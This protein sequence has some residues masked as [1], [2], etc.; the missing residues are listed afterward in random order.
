MAEG[1]VSPVPSGGRT[2][3]QAVR[4]NAF[5]S[6]VRNGSPTR[7]VLAASPSPARRR[8]N[9]GRY[10]AERQLLEG[11][12]QLLGGVSREQKH[13]GLP[14]LVLRAFF[15]MPLYPVKYVQ[16]LIQ[17][18]YEVSPPEKRFSFVFQQYM[19]YYPGVV[20]YARI[21]YRAEGWKGLYRGAFASFAEDVVG[22]TASTF[23]R[24]VVQS[25]VNKIPLPFYT[26][27]S[28][29]VPDTDPTDSLPSILTR[30]TRTFLGNLIS[31]FI[32][33]F[34]IHPFHVITVRT[35]AQYVGKETTHISVVD[36]IKEI[37]RV[38]GVSGFYA[39]IVPA[40]LG[41]VCTCVIHSSLWLMFEI[42]VA[43]ISHDMGKLVVK[44]LIAMP[45]LA[46]VPNSYSYPFFLMMNVMA[47]NNSGLAAGS[48][49][50]M[51]IFTGW[52]DCYRYLKSTGHLY[53]GSVILFA[54]FAYRDLPVRAGNSL[55]N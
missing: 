28:G 10:S 38:E 1:R 43:N 34:A 30:G 21:I 15:N 5:L 35:M 41:H 16:R 17:L 23:V 44:T 22:L 48:P 49:P 26:A 52:M 54:R 32:V 51:P 4:E 40:L 55:A 33:Q 12:Q 37:Y 6:A 42:I 24:P 39:G 8:P 2:S 27:E 47:V 45:L 46:Y 13:E 7:D 3:P 11:A 20:G 18:G 53:R 50:N 31:N 14:Q 36:S 19:Y 25:A 9:Q 29:D